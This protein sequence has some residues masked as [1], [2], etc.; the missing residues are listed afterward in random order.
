[1]RLAVARLDGAQRLPPV[2]AV[3]YGSISTAVGS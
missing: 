3:A 2:S 1:V